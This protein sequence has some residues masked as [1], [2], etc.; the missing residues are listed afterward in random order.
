MKAVIYARYSSDNQREESIDAQVRSIK[1]FA[2]K[3]EF[4]I[5]KIYADEAKS[6]TSADRPNFLQMICDS[7]FGLFDAV[8][9]HKLD[10]FS[11]NRYDSAFYKRK[12]KENGVRL[13][14]ALEPIDDSPESIILESV[15]EGMAEYYSKNL[16]RETMK[17]LKENAYKAHF[18][19]GTPPLGYNISQD[20]T[21]I[22]NESEAKIV[23]DIF[24]LYIDGLGYAQIAEKLNAIGYKTKA[25]RPYTK[26]SIHDI[27]LNE[28]YIGIYTFNKRP[29]RSIDKKRNSHKCK[30]ESEIIKVNDGVPA[31]I[32]SD[33]FNKVKQK[34]QYRMHGPRINSNTFYILTGKLI[35]GE[36]KSSYSGNCNYP[37]PGVKYTKYSCV[38]RQ[39]N[40][41]CTNRSINQ[42]KL[43]NEVVN[44]LKANI[45]NENSIN[46]LSIK[47]Y[48]YIRNLTSTSIEELE[49]LT[50]QKNSIQNKLDK[51]FDLYLDDAIDKDVLSKKINAF[52]QQINYIEEQ[53]EELSSNEYNWVTE[54]II[55]K[56]LY[57]SKNNLESN[58]LKLM[59]K[60]IHE[61]IS[62]ITIYKNSLKFDFSIDVSMGGNAWYRERG[63]NP[64]DIA[65]AGF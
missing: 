4:E 27:L 37:R 61:F 28:K 43:E 14:S 22:I 26:A 52:K 62:S 48:N 40:N 29:S 3:N 54:D 12:L 34:M 8:I 58:N 42:E 10:R 7:S 25:G 33:I 20:K 9:V 24:N 51:V 45:F 13:V 15:L 11:R 46:Q 1:D 56:Y 64:H 39:K 36:C 32:S 21:Y 57:I 41:S 44:S 60:V 2:N 49:N 31:I 30:S 55:K 5:V 38:G 63:S 59:Q 17:G 47:M 18:N 65:T 23:K 16:A 53:I 19:G 6:A 50:K 35:C